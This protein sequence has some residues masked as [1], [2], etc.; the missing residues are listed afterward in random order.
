[1]ITVTITII[2][3]TMSINIRITTIKKNNNSG[4][5]IRPAFLQACESTSPLSPRAALPGT[6]P[7]KEIIR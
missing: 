2:V 7:E 3:E 6:E 1:M 4:G 5:G